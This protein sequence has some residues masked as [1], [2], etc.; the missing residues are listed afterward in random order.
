MRFKVPGAWRDLALMSTRYHTHCHRAFELRAATLV[1]TLMSLDALRRPERF[2]HFLLVC[3]ADKRGRTGREAV[4]YPEAGHM[5]SAAE[6]MRSV[7]AGQVVRGVAPD[8]RADAI[9]RA[10]I[11]AVKSLDG[12]TDAQ[13]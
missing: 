5:R 10:R 11:T 13:L 4:A 1:D 6:A 2:E 9:R 8:K 12:A 7:N 3:T